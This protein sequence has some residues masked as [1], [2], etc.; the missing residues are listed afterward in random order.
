MGATPAADGRPK[1]RPTITKT[2]FTLLDKAALADALIPVTVAF[3]L[4]KST[5]EL[6]LVSLFSWIVLKL[7][8]CIQHQ[9]RNSAPRETWL[10]WCVLLALVLLQARNIIL[11]DDYRGPVMFLLIGSG[12]L[13]GSQLT[14]R[15]WL[16]LLTWMSLAVAPIALFFA[17]QLSATGDWSFQN[18]FDLYYATMQRSLGSIN[19]LATL[20][21]FLTLAAWYSSTQEGRLFWRGVHLVLCALGYWVILG[22]DSRM[23]ILAM[24]LA[25][26]LPWLGLRLCHRMKRSQWVLILMGAGSLLGAAAWKL[27]IA[28]DIGSDTMRLRMASC[29]VRKGMLKSTE[30]FWMGSGYDTSGLREACESVRPGLSFGHAHN[31]WAQVAGNHGLLGLIVLMA[32]TGLILRGLW[33]QEMAV[34]A[35]RNWSPWDSTN[36]SEISLGLNLALLFCALSTTVQEFSPLNQLLIGLVA[37]AACINPVSTDDGKGRRQDI[38]ENQHC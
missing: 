27:V 22:T 12:L 33:T 29:W 2:W 14:Q 23:A 24:P 25:V 16:R 8:S 38:K 19:R 37:G 36:W 20:T 15:H 31:T 32:L 7:I 4:S 9:I 26:A 13:I 17:I 1:P 30:R 6:G 35:T 5:R 21:T 18:M 11:R 10:S 3:H 34:T 28:P